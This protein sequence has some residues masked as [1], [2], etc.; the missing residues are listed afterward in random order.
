MPTAAGTDAVDRLADALLARVA[1]LFRIEHV[2]PADLDKPVFEAAGDGLAGRVLDSLDLAVLGV[3]LED[4]L[5]TP[6]VAS[7]ELENVA[8][9]RELAVVAE[10][11]CNPAALDR[12]CTR[13]APSGVT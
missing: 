6:L 1:A 3:T 11:R 13:W 10:P 4:E 9:L 5:G 8:T 7:G 2:G 12:F